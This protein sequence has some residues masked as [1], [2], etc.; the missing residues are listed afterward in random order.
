[1]FDGRPSL[2]VVRS[3]LTIERS[4]LLWTLESSSTCCIHALEF[5]ICSGW[6]NLT[7]KGLAWRAN[8]EMPAAF[9]YLA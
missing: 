8:S 5:G 2:A 1:M 4:S 6:R 7:R 9:V 3:T